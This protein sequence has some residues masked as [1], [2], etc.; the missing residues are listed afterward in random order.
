[1][2]LSS[3]NLNAFYNLAQ[4]KNFTKAAK[5]IGITQSA[6]SQRI[7]KLEEEVE[8]VLVVRESKDIQ[9]TESGE[10]LLR[11][12]EQNKKLEDEI[13]NNLKSNNETLKGVV[14][15]ASFSSILRSAIMPSLS[16]LMRDN[17][18]LKLYLL[19]T[20]L[21]ELYELLRASKVDYIITNK[22]PRTS[23][24]DT[25]FLGYEDNVLVESK[26]N[27]FK[28]IYLDHDSFDVTTESY[29]KL[30]PKLNNNITK[31]YL[32]DVYGLIDG[33]EMGYGRAILPIHLIKSKKDFKVL[34][35]K[36]RL[37]VPLNLVFYKSAYRTQL[38]KEI[39]NSI[40]SYFKKNFKQS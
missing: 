2:E 11:Y 25:Y 31:R 17:Q 37:R 24:L 13:I 16:N 15:I 1:M 32:D 3:I 36:T 39:I 21:S 5:E 4:I 26:N 23:N 6:L 14:R 7:K 27:K 18:F 33:V 30:R 8:S 34:Y 29:F 40:V 28:N 22:L 35:P 20:E 10:L 12:C 19:N 9:L 38:E